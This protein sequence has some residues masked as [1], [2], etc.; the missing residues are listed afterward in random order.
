MVLLFALNYYVGVMVLTGRREM[1]N[2][3]C[4]SFKVVDDDKPAVVATPNN[5]M[6]KAECKSH[7][8]ILHIKISKPF[9]HNKTNSLFT[10][11]V[12]I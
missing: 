8:L 10:L 11:L 5:P 9:M 2:K 6:K 12:Y 3:H 4:L 1:E 7:F